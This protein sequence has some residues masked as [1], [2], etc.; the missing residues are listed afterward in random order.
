[1]Q[2]AAG[3]GAEEDADAAFA[4]TGNRRAD[5]PGEAVGFQ[6]QLRQAVVAAIVAG[7]RFWQFFSV[8]RSNLADPGV[9]ANRFKGAGLQP[10]TTFAQAGQQ[11]V[12][13]VAEAGGGGVTGQEQRVHDV[14][15]VR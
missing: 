1:M 8:D 5:A 12:K 15:L 6:P 14:P 4:V 13:A 11:G 7:E 10:A 3:A 2:D 9:E